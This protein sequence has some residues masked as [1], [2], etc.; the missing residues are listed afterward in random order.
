M[1]RQ[2]VAESSSSILDG[3]C[4]GRCRRDQVGPRQVARGPYFL[5]AGR[6]GYV[7]R[8]QGYIGVDLRKSTS[9]V[10]DHRRVHEN[11]FTRRRRTV[12]VRPP[13]GQ[14]TDGRAV[15]LPPRAPPRNGD[16]DSPG[17]V[18]TTRSAGDSAWP[19]GRGPARVPVC[20]ADRRAHGNP[21]APSGRAQVITGT[22]RASHASHSPHRDR[23]AGRCPVRKKAACQVL[24]PSIVYCARKGGGVQGQESEHVATGFPVDRSNGQ[25]DGSDGRDRTA[26]RP[27]H[28]DLSDP[29]PSDYRGGRAANGARAAAAA[30]AKARAMAAVAAGV[31]RVRIIGAAGCAVCRVC[32]PRPPAVPDPPRAGCGTACP[33]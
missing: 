25:V 27:R 31:S 28:S 20:T 1:V 16:A 26:A 12:I 14:E 8:A 22:L 4:G 7:I 9:G 2:P 17:P 19:A 13:T 3:I 33:P 15:S 23:I 18:E 24:R 5:L 6:P 32:P 30:R 21:D 10:V 11:L 29:A